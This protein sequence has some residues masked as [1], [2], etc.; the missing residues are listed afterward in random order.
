MITALLYTLAAVG[1]LE[2]AFVVAAVR[3][4]LRGGGVSA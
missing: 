1:V 4:L 3:S 2:A